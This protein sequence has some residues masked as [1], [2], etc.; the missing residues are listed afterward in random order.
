MSAKGIQGF[1]SLVSGEQKSAAVF[2]L[3]VARGEDSRLPAPG[4]TCSA[5]FI[6]WCP[7]QSAVFTS[8]CSAVTWKDIV[9]SLKI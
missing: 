6:W 8:L 1:V 5:P 2:A 4:W 3:A 7:F 9:N